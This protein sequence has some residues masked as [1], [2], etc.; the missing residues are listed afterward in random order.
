M[1]NRLSSSRK[2]KEQT[3]TK[4]EHRKTQLERHYKSL[5]KLALLCGIDNPDG[6]KLS[7]KLRL[8]EQSAHRDAEAYCNGDI[9]MELWEKREEEYITEVQKLFNN[10]LEGFFVNGDPRGYA[11]KI[12]D[13]YLR[14]KEAAGNGKYKDT[15]LQTDW[16]GYGILAP[17]ITG[18]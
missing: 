7:S 4:A 2:D 1:S 5:E 6:K 15:E 10:K 8:I 13:N 14:P 3:P 16:G 12:D 11:L 18:D 17:E 9:D